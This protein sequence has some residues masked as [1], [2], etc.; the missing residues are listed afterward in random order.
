MIL[1]IEVEGGPVK[2]Q[3]L[4]SRPHL[5]ETGCSGDRVAGKQVPEWISHLYEIL[6]KALCYRNT[7][8]KMTQYK[9]YPEPFYLVYALN[10]I[11]DLH[12]VHSYSFYV[13]PT[14]EGKSSFR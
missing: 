8:A 9:A 4:R 5:P 10:V 3:K 11:T 14:T 2:C 7:H 6:P 1:L 13:K 12:S